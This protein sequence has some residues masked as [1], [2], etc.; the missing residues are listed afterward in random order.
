MQP[1]HLAHAQ[2]MIRLFMAFIPARAV[3][4]AAKLGIADRLATGPRTAETLAAETG[5]RAAALGRVLHILAAAG[6]LTEDGGTFAL[7]PLGATLRG[8]HP[9]S[10]RDYLQ[11]FHDLHYSSVAEAM[12]TLTAGT[13][14]FP[15]THGGKSVFAVLH[16][17][18]EFAKTFQSGLAQR[19]RI[20]CGALL[21]AYDFSDCRTIVDVGG[22]HG[23]LLSAI[24]A[25]HAH[26]EG[27][28]LDLP[29]A[30][31]AARA[32][33]GGPLPRCE[34]VAGDFFT[35]VPAGAD[36]YILKLVL[37]DWSDEECVRILTSCRRAMAPS[38]RLLVI[39]GL[40][41]P[42]GRLTLTDLIDFIMLVSFTGKERTEA[43]FK[44]LMAQAGLAHAR[45]VRTASEL[46]VL[47]ARPA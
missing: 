28:L 45:T 37:H 4:L 31:E 26:V 25:R 12:H 36:A 34:L 38:A 8:D 46:A 40:I 1:D 33:R 15:P 18:P 10:V 42:G 5:T 27:V 29:P 7:T 3:Y 47:E 22:G 32:G 19:S 2:E 14:A 43:E 16:D 13:P 35:E 41:E 39:E 21:D 30:L 17:D 24:L 11:I 6:V 20:D 23:A 9:A 44:A